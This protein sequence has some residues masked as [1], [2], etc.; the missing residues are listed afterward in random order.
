MN[1]AMKRAYEE[2]VAGLTPLEAYRMLPE[3]RNKL[4][5]G[6]P[7]DKEF[8]Q[9]MLLAC[10]AVIASCN[11][12]GDEIDQMVNAGFPSLDSLSEEERERIAPA[13]AYWEETD[14]KE[15]EFHLNYK[16]EMVRQMTHGGM[17]EE[18][19]LQQVGLSAEE[20]HGKESSA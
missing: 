5:D 18:I 19:A 15:K 9:M 1:E 13:V 16:R 7:Y 12:V 11:D 14:R 2:A 20:F 10:E 4:L 6:N 8:N 3:L 17:D